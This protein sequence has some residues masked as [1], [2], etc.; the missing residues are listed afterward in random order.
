MFEVGM[1]LVE[2][3]DYSVLSQFTGC[4]CFS[5]SHSAYKVA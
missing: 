3:R 1:L 2:E 5:E 4:L